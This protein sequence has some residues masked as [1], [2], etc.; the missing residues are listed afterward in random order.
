MS[1]ISLGEMPYQLKEAWNGCEIDIFEGE[2]IH[3]SQPDGTI[4][5]T[6]MIEG[7]LQEYSPYMCKVVQCFKESLY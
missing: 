2:I 1:S 6:Q 7:V 4:F 3:L 5:L